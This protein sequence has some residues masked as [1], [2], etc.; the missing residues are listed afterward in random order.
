MQ[1]KPQTKIFYVTNKYMTYFNK[2]LKTE[3]INYYL[4]DINQ[5]TCYNCIDCLLFILFE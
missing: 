3:I 4:G 1:K 5:Q 2:I